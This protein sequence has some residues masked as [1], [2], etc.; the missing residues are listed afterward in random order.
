MLNFIN[1]SVQKIFGTKYERDV[2]NYA[3]IVDE[4]NEIYEGLMN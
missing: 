1:K 2:K 4:I 3:P